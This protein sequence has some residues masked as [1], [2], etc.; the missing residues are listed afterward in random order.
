MTQR[1]TKAVFKQTGSCNQ[2]TDA[3]NLN[4]KEKKKKKD[5]LK[6]RNKENKLKIFR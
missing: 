4:K 3:I 6:Q 5:R 1:K 2:V